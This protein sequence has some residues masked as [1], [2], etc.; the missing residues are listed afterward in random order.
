MV[1]IAAPLHGQFSYDK[2]ED[3]SGFQFEKPI[4]FYG[5]PRS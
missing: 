5:K 3:V 4:E 1:A 2:I